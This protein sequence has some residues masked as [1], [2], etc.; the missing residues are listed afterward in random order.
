MPRD[1][2]DVDFK[3]RSAGGLFPPK[4]P[5]VLG[6]ELLYYHPLAPE[7]V[8]PAY[9]L[10][11]TALLTCLRSGLPFPRIFFFSWVFL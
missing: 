2:L 8:E 3:G 5:L 9:R 7:G 1:L 4:H 11:E 6:I 10:I